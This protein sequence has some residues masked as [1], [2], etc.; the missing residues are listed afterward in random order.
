MTAQKAAIMTPQN[1][2]E[3]DWRDH[4]S[5]IRGRLRRDA[6][7]ASGNWFRTGGPADLLFK[8]EDPEDLAAFLAQL[9]PDVPVTA[10][11]VGSNVL[12]RDGGLAGAVIRL[13][14]GFT[15]ISVSGSTVTAGAGAPDAHVAEAA[16]Q[17]G[18]TGLE[19]LSGIPGTV[20]GALAMNAGAYGNDTAST[21]KE[22]TYITRAGERRTVTVEE[23]G[24][25]YRH[26]G[27]LPG[28][29]VFIEAVFQA[30]PGDPQTIRA[31][32]QEIAASRSASQPT[33]GAT[34]GSTFRNPEGHKAWELIDRAGGRGLKVGEAQMSEKHCNFMM[35]LGQASA[36]DLEA[37]GEELR[38][39]VREQSGVTLEWEIRRLGRDVPKPET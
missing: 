37:L 10:L 8:P 6:P 33:R 20:G 22:A 11:G 29:A 19:F 5:D 26:C 25:S 15:D 13:G 32:M 39:R 36:A 23:L 34:G 27:G 16:A 35:N 1:E 4:L 24:Y 2:K 18:L 14:R 17:A 12:I 7:L 9:P 3:T 30:R 38:R 28:G 21:L 31:R